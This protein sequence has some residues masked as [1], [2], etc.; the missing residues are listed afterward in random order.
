MRHFLT[1]Q[2]ELKIILL[3]NYLPQRKLNDSEP[4]TQTIKYTNLFIELSITG[5]GV[6]VIV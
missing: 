6:K 2:N 1:C 5:Y 3:N 4:I